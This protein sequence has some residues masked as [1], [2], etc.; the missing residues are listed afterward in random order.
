MRSP[1]IHTSPNHQCRSIATAS[2]SPSIQYPTLLMALNYR[3]RQLSTEGSSSATCAPTDDMAT[4]L[5]NP[6]DS[7]NSF[8]LGTERD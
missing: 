2:S 5:S 1:I 6:D 3:L 7:A 4:I 8:L